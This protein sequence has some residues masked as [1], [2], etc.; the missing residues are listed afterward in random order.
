MLDNLTGEELH[1][2]AKTLKEGYKGKRAFLIETSGGIT[3]D[4]LA[5]RIGPGKQPF[6]FESD[7]RRTEGK[8]EEGR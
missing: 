8:R 2:T 5:G 4:S 6:Q 1:D 7:I 3:E